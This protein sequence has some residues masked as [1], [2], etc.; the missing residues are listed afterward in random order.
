MIQQL[1]T[2]LSASLNAAS[3]CGC[4]GAERSMSVSCPSSTPSGEEHTAHTTL[5]RDKVW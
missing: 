5:L 2:H 1:S 3:C 4:V